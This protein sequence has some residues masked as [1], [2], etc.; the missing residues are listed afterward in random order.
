MS[1]AEWSLRAIKDALCHV[2][3]FAL[4]RMNYAPSNVDYAKYLP[5]AVAMIREAGK[6]LYVKSDLRKF[7]RPGFLWPEER[8]Q[9]Y[10]DWRAIAIAARATGLVLMELDREFRFAPPR[11]W[12]FD[13]A[14][15]AHKVAVEIEGGVWARG[16]HVRPRGYAADCEKYT[17]AAALGW[18]VLR[19]TTD[20]LRREPLNI[21]RQIADA[22]QGE[23]E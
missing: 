20:R 11:R 22:T 18:R 13:Y 6:A 1:A 15:P 21:A 17:A 19:Y 4:G 8:D 23:T 14:F 3:Q 16:R 7:A 2:D 12:R 5:K 9:S 10:T